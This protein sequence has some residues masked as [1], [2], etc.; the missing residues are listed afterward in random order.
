MIHEK[1]E[2]YRHLKVD[3]DSREGITVSSFK[4]RPMHEKVENN[5]SSFKAGLKT[6]LFMQY[7][8]GATL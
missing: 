5:V 8:S 7:I 6:H 3:C 4:G 1:V 2:M